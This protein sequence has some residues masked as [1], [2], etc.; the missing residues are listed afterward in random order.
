MASA[1]RGRYEK[2]QFVFLKGEPARL[3]FLIKAGRVKLSKLCGG[4]EVTL[5]IRQA[6]DLIGLNVL[7]DDDESY[8]VT[9]TCMEDTMLCGLTREGFERLVL[10]HPT[11][12]LQV[13]RNLSTRLAGLSE[14]VE[15]MALTS[16]EERLYVV[17]LQFARDH[18]V[19]RREGVAIRFP[20]THEELG[21]LVG[22]HRVSVTRAMKSLTQAGKILRQ[23]HTLVLPQ[24]PLA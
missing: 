10:Q 9:A 11:I 16:L 17:L 13:I 8:P 20:L 4:S 22:A 23:G 1:W 3:M 19:V 2:G 18:G 21:F 5:D 15:S 24:F 6:G 14:R 7:T 12:G